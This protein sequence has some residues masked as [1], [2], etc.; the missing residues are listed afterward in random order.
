MDTRILWEALLS[1]HTETQPF[2]HRR[3]SSQVGPVSP[4][5]SY[6][7]KEGPVV[8]TALSTKQSL[9]TMPAVELAVDLQDLSP[10]P[11]ALAPHWQDQG[12]NHVGPTVLTIAPRAM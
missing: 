12:E 5:L 8:L 4:F 1:F 3:P 2:C 6:I 10:S 7:L 9:S 11:Q